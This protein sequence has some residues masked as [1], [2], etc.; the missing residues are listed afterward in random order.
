LGGF[1]TPADPIAVATVKLKE[2]A[3]NKIMQGKNSSWI[4]ETS[5]FQGR[6]IRRNRWWQ[7]AWQ[8]TSSN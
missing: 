7:C 1:S 6:K 3:V 5:S 4:I 8:M 2:P